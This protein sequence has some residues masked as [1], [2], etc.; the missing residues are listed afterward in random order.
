MTEAHRCEKLFHSFYA[1]VPAETRTRDLLIA[2]VTHYR[3]TTTPP[4]RV[5]LDKWRYLPEVETWSTAALS[6]SGMRFGPSGVQ[7]FLEQPFLSMCN[8]YRNYNHAFVLVQSI[9]ASN[10]GIVICR[11]G[12]I[13]LWTLCLVSHV[14]TSVASCLHH[15]VSAGIHCWSASLGEGGWTTLG[16]TI[17]GWDRNKTNYYYLPRFFIPKVLKLARVKNVC[18]EWLWLGLIVLLLLL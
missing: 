10:A 5:S 2:N 13:I 11:R 4:C 15:S 6:R 17:Q 16:D 9:H 12:N 7:I 14:L 18:P 3:N 1:I 8:K